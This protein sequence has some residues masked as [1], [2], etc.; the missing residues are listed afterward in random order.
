MTT[1]YFEDKGQVAAVTLLRRVLWQMS[2]N[3]SANNAVTINSIWRPSRGPSS[4]RPVV[5]LLY[6]G[7]PRVTTTMS[8]LHTC[9][10]NRCRCNH[11]DRMTSC[12]AASGDEMLQVSMTSDTTAQYRPFYTP[13]NSNTVQKLKL[14]SR[15][16]PVAS[17]PTTRHAYK[18]YKSRSRIVRVIFASRVVNVWN[19]LPHT[20]GFASHAARSIRNADFGKFLKCNDV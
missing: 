2:D 8:S 15:A 1:V 9:L 20:V 4:P 13:L 17:L 7:R 19:S 12:L 11:S 3:C 16:L 14:P 10:M 5:Y 18:L 6:S